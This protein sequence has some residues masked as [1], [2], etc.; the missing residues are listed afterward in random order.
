[1]ELD[2]IGQLAEERAD[3]SAR[4]VLLADPDTTLLAPLFDALLLKHEPATENLWKNG[5]WPAL[6]LR[7]AL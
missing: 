7:S 6:N 2:W 5:L 1:L 4:L 3:A